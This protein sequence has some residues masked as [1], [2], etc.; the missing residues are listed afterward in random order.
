MISTSSMDEW[1]KDLHK[2]RIIF[3]ILLIVHNCV[4][5]NAPKELTSLLHQGDSARTLHLKETRIGTKYGDRAFSHMAPKLWNMLPIDI[6][7][8]ENTDQFKK[9]LK[10][11]LMIEG[12]IFD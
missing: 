1:F 12:D 2:H 4:L 10:S 6:R 7:K 5:G 3:K 9:R 8:T 11:F